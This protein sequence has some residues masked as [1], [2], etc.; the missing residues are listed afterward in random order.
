MTE[1]NKTLEKA[2][3]KAVNKATA[4][5]KELTKQQD[6][7][8]SVMTRAKARAEEA[9]KKLNGAKKDIKKN[10]EIAPAPV[11]KTRGRPKK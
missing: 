5:A 8:K 4:T 3:K 9:L 2:Q 7:I 1:A 6:E 11:K 10:T